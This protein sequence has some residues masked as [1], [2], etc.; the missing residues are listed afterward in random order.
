[1]IT[2]D[3]IMITIEFIIIA[4][5]SYSQ[6]LTRAF[7]VLLFRKLFLLCFSTLSHTIAA[8]NDREEE[9]SP[10]TYP[11]TS[12]PTLNGLTTVSMEISIIM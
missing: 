8:I 1:M 3:F 10:P 11:R 7:D 4:I 12:K 5:D 2:I 9:S 6:D